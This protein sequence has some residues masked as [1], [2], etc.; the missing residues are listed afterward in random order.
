MHP[1]YGGC[2]GPTSPSI[3]RKVLSCLGKK[4]KMGDADEEPRCDKKNLAIA[5]HLKDLE[6]GD[7]QLQ[8]ANQN[9]Q[10]FE[11]GNHLSLHNNL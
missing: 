2:L 11:R 8:V 5:R 10:S 4:K 9:Q 7:A 1:Q 3:I 6:E